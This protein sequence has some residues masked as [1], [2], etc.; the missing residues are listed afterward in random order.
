MKKIDRII[1]CIRTLREDVAMSPTNSANLPGKGGGLGANSQNPNMSGIDPL[2][3]FPKKKKTD[4]IDFRR[5]LPKYKKWI[6][7]K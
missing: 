4:G 6:P 5:V 3:G 2:L 1:N 7:T